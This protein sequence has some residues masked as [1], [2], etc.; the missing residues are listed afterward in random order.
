MVDV[1]VT[2]A[3]NTQFDENEESSI[4]TITFT[5]TTAFTP[6]NGTNYF[7]VATLTENSTSQEYTF[8]KVGAGTEIDASTAVPFTVE[9]TMS[10]TS[11]AVVSDQAIYYTSGA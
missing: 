8:S 6:K 4:L 5:N 11:S 7:Y 10:F 2:V 3:N 1:A 9:N